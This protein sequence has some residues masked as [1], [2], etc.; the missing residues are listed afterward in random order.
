MWSVLSIYTKYKQRGIHS[1]LML[2][3]IKE[4]FFFIVTDNAQATQE[5]AVIA[6]C[7]IVYTSFIYIHFKI[8]GRSVVL[9]KLCGSTLLD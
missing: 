2:S 5:C 6:F 3:T 8:C 9:W 7:L 4:V 1:L